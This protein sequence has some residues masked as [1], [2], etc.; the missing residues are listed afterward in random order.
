MMNGVNFSLNLT[1]PLR[2]TALCAYP[3]DCQGHLKSSVKKWIRMDQVLSGVPGTFPC[4]DDVKVQGSTEERHD[5]HLL[6]TVERACKVELKFNRNK[7]CIEKQEIEYFGRIFTPQGVEPCPKKV[8][9]IAMLAAPKDKLELQ[10]LLGTVNFMP[11]FIPYLT[12]KTHLMRSLLKRDVH[13]LWASDMQK[14][15]DTIKN[16]IAKLFSSLTMNPTR[17]PLLKPMH[18]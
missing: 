5:I 14:E 11:T 15:L 12:K 1:H 7:C 10:S 16:E 8:K 6:E 4:A 3:L 13:F 2:N 9:S 18:L 17:Q